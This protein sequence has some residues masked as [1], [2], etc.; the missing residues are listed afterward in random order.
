MCVG[1]ASINFRGLIDL[2]RGN[3]KDYSEKY[4]LNIDSAWAWP[5]RTGH[6]RMK[7]LIRPGHGRTFF[8][9]EQRGGANHFRG[10][11]PIRKSKE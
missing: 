5:V 9:R 2:S 1:G 10:S 8:M 4:H 11:I 7:K 6:G 3:Y